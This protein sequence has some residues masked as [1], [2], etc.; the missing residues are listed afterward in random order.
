[1]NNESDGLFDDV[2]TSP[3]Q[4]GSSAHTRRLDEILA[5]YRKQ[6]AMIPATYIPS[7]APA[8]KKTAD[9]SAAY[10]DLCGRLTAIANGPVQ[11]RY[12]LDCATLG[13]NDMDGEQSVSALIG[14]WKSLGKPRG[15][16]VI[17]NAS[18]QLR[19]SLKMKNLVNGIF[20]LEHRE[21]GT[22]IESAEA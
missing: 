6:P 19:G 13:L 20:R 9:G 8:P 17:G 5:E 14:F 3:T 22:A 21:T 7:P 11:D 1:M 12:E 4:H 10:E 16:I 15:K 2:P 18:E